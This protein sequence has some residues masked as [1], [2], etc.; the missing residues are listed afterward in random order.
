MLTK[1]MEPLFSAPTPPVASEKEKETLAML[2]R[3]AIDQYG[4]NTKLFF[5]LSELAK[6]SGNEVAKSCATLAFNSISS[7]YTD[8]IERKGV[9]RTSD[10][11]SVTVKRAKRDATKPS[12][13]G[14]LTMEEK[15]ETKA[16]KP[17]KENEEVRVLLEVKKISETEDSPKEW[18]AR[19]NGSLV[20]VKKPSE[21]ILGLAIQYYIADAR[22]FSAFAFFRFNAGQVRVP[23]PIG[24]D[25]YR[26]IGLY[27]EKKYQMHPPYAT[28][29][30][31]NANVILARDIM[32]TIVIS[33]DETKEEYKSQVANF[34]STFG[35]NKG[36]GK[37]DAKNVKFVD[38]LRAGFA[39]VE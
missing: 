33:G 36:T 10:G 6:V 11:E 13:V 35:M 3:M 18:T 14:L 8:G 16:V 24:A 32:T 39:R 1:K 12:S 30:D 2:A 38:E 26:I 37:N 17:K 4:D 25:K 23:M 22:N 9:K 19:T 27:D 5:F 21:T 29:T 31:G 15:K 20:L 7:Q 34:L 28:Y